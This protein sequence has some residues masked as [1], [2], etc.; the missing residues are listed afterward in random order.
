MLVKTFA[1]AVIGVDAQ[2]ITVEVNAGGQVAAGKQFYFLV[3]L[4]DNTV[5]ESFQRFEAAIKCRLQS[6]SN[7]ISGQS[8]ASRYSQR[9]L[10]LRFAYRYWTFGS[11]HAN[12]C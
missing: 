6:A 8:C 1:S 10:C 7:E 9:R 12:S 4:P 2:T 3:G 11:Y 5:R